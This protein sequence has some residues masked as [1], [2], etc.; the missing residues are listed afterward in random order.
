MSADED[1]RVSTIELFFDL[2][3]VYAITQTTQLMADHL[4]PLGV[5]QG[6]AMLAVLWW[7]WCSYAWLGTTIHVATGSRGSRCSGRWP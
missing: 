7:C 5:G 3:F 4:S 6:L 2:V 1:H